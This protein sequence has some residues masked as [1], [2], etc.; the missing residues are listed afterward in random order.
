MKS[1]ADLKGM[2]VAMAG[3]PGS[4]GEY[5]AAKALERGRLTIR[6]VQIL[7]LGNSDMPA[8]L[9]NKSIDAGIFRHRPMPTRRSEEG[10][11]FPS[12][13]TSRRGP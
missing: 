12:K 2:K 3:G 13:K 11:P 5:L 7:N 1:V 4:G 10:R 8:A 9:E 6:D